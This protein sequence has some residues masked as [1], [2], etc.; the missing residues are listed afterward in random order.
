MK[1]VSILSGK[2]NVISAMGNL[3]LRVLHFYSEKN[4]DIEVINC[5]KDTLG[6]KL[7]LEVKINELKIILVNIYAPNIDDPNVF[8]NMFNDVNSFKYR[9][10]CIICGDFNLVLHPEI[11]YK[12][13]KSVQHNVHA[14]SKLLT[15]IND[16]NL[17]DIYREL[18]GNTRKYTWNRTN[19]T[20]QGRL[21]FFLIT[22]NLFDFVKNCDIGISYRSD[23]SIIILQLCFSS[24]QHGKGLWKFNNSLLMDIEY[25]NCINR[26]I[27][28]VE[29]QYCLPVYNF[30]NI[31]LLDKTKI[32]F[33]INDQ[34]FLETLLMEIRGENI[35]YASFK[36]KER[37]ND[38]ESIQ[39]E[40][41]NIEG[42][43]NDL[44]KERLTR[45]QKS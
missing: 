13:Y 8:I 2:G 39:N 3:M 42:N 17:I 19:T 38:E 11:D 14:R 1:T 36:A 28:E 10:K 21:D 31:L 44:N 6:T 12:N 45:L 5:K 26:K 35:F 27:E 37:G 7:I 41:L 20:Q 34:L 43:L 32:Q 4:L 9:D 25:V 33:V 24:V 30:E 15:L 16:N 40:I 22:Y 18:N 23:H 29:L